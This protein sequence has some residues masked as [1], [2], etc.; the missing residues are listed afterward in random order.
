MK[1][2]KALDITIQQMTDDVQ[3]MLHR[4]H[5]F[6]FVHKMRF[7]SVALSCFDKNH[8]QG[9][10]ASWR[11]CGIMYSMQRVLGKDSNKAEIAG[12]S[13]PY[14]RRTWQAITCLVMHTGQV[15]ELCMHSECAVRPTWEF[16]MKPHVLHD[17]HIPLIRTYNLGTNRW[18]ALHTSC[19]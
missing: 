5:R 16:N 6:L 1:L 2:N 15:L 9:T 12:G 3:L 11:C 17:S 19:D 13:D 4:R 18:G 14:Q 10:T 7:K 8:N